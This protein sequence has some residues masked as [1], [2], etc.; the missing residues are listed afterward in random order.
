MNAE[1][2]P[3]LLEYV[4][5]DSDLSPA[6]KETM[7]RFDKTTETV[8]AYTAE[9]GLARRALAH[10]HIEVAALTVRDENG[11]RDVPPGEFDGEIPI[12]GVRLR[13]PIGLFLI[14]ST[15]RQSTGHAD[16]ISNRVFEVRA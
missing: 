9:A 14:K 3:D 2:H 16:L 10:P 13:L 5:E 7:F 6:E 15:P 8:T 1:P 4:E 12:T 11:L